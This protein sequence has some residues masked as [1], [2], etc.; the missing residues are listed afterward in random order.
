MDIADPLKDK[1]IEE[2]KDFK[3]T[4]DKKIEELIAQVDSMESIDNT[5]SDAEIDALLAQA[6]K[7]VITERIFN[8]KTKRVD[9]NA[10][11]MDVE[12]ELDRPLPEK[13]FEAL[14]DGFLKAREAIADRNN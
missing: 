3:E 12:A 8:E 9:A 11:L 6:Q 14:K 2:D 1:A 7:E 5:V 13:V 4:I 10:L